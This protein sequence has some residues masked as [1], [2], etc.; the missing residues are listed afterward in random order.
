MADLWQ[1][2][3]I[4]F[5]F[6]RIQRGVENGIVV[7]LQI[8]YTHTSIYTLGR[9][10]GRSLQ[11]VCHSNMIDEKGRESH[12]REFVIISL[13]EWQKKRREKKRRD[14]EC[15]KAWRG[16][17]GTEI[18]L[19]HSS[20]IYQGSN[21]WFTA[22]PRASPTLNKT[23]SS[24]PGKTLTDRRAKTS[25]PPVW[26]VEDFCRQA[27]RQRCLKDKNLRGAAVNKCTDKLTDRERGQTNRER[28]N[29]V[30]G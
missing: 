4:V 28:R 23:P 3:E 29:E 13:W 7:Y 20:N 30:C 5:W 8:T 17:G 15:G 26:S 1:W 12:I 14:K 21:V 11:S 22:L 24:C 27:H 6:T 25:L 16:G 10:S 18:A 2:K 9:L 19:G